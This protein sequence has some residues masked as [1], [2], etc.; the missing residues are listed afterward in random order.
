MAHHRGRRSAGLIVLRRKRASGVGLYA[1]HHEV[2][3]GD[4]LA[5]KAFRR[6]RAARAPHSQEQTAAGLK[7]RQFRE[8]FGVI[9]QVSIQVIG[10]NRKLVGLAVSAGETA[11]GFFAEPV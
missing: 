4:K 2:I 3:A 9:A 5:W 11:A 8:S 10:D 6:L 1:K 7:R